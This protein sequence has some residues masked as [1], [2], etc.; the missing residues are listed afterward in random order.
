VAYVFDSV[1][2]GN[3]DTYLQ[4]ISE[5]RD[6]IAAD[7]LAE[8][9]EDELTSVFALRD[10]H[11]ELLDR[12]LRGCLLRTVQRVAGDAL[13]ELLE[14]ILRFGVLVTNLRRGAIREAHG[15]EQLSELY[16][17]FQTQMLFFVSNHACTCLPL[18]QEFTA[19]ADRSRPFKRCM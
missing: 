3:F 5:L 17:M 14:L 8:Y 2:G 13:R 18:V 1:I 4:R 19:W 6:T 7:G 16:I 10:S 12:I 11:S 15:A 9:S